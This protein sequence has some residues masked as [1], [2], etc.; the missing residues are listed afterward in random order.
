MKRSDKFLRKCLEFKTENV[1]FVKKIL[2][3]SNFKIK[4]DKLF[5]M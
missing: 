2:S 3:K 4:G 1:F 5:L